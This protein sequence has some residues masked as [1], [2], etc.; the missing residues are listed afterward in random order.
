MRETSR[1]YCLLNS[2]ISR[3]N[4]ELHALIYQIFE[5]FLAQK[6]YTCPNTHLGFQATLF[7]KKIIK[8]TDIL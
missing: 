7:Y 3:S 8:K 4:G 5:Y 6:K 2:A 1:H